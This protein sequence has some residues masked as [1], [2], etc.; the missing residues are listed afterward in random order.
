VAAR[1]TAWVWDRLHDGTVGSNPARNLDVC[2]FLVLYVVR[3]RFLRPADHSSRG[4]LPRVMCLTE[5]DGESLIMRR[6]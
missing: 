2:R 6:P 4:V 5:C 3:Y 1:S